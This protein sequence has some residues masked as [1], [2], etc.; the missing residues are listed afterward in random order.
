MKKLL[1]IGHA[2]HNKTKST[3]FIREMF[4]EKY[5][6]TQFD[7]DPYIDKFDKFKKLSNKK[8]DVIVLFQIMPS[9]YKLKKYIK[10][11]QIVFFPMYDGTP[12]IKSPI[13]NEYKNCIIINFS[14]TLHDKCKKVGLAS[15]YIQYFPKPAEIL[16][17]GQEKKV[18]LWQR[19][20]QI[21]IQTVEKTLGINNIEQ[22]YLHNA[23]D[24]S[25][26]FVKPYGKWKEKSIISKWFETKEQMNK[27]L[28]ECAIYYAPRRY[29]GIGMSFLEA[30][31]VG[32]C[33][34][35]PNYPTMN[36]YITNGINGYLYNYKHPKK[37]KIRNV[38]EIQENT[39]KFIADGY[40]KWEQDKHQIL[41]WIEADAK[42]HSN[43][44]K[45]SLNL[46]ICEPKKKQIKITIT[47]ISKRTIEKWIIYYLFDFL[48]IYFKKRKKKQKV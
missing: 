45:Q 31:A 37:I 33:I 36:E 30:M 3:Q 23:P 46:Y 27:Y 38:R 15:F 28:Q 42:E 26:K 5:E 35:A 10:C 48:P 32:R 20:N 12:S 6:V 2:Y 14:K 18:F 8:F 9:I 24:P 1:Y 4:T 11:K 22:L 47:L 34:I 16:S 13:W 17:M 25:F 7:F 41:D 39:I 40:K 29:E 44:L 19:T 21:T 43:Q